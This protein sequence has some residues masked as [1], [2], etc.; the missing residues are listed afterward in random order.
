MKS[1]LLCVL[2]LLDCGS[3]SLVW[4][5]T[6][7]ADFSVQQVLQETQKA[8]DQGQFEKAL[9]LLDSI[10]QQKSE[11]PPAAR[12]RMLSLVQVGKTL[13]GLDEYEKH[14]KTVG[15]EDE[16]L[17]RQLAI[18]SILPLRSDMREQMRGAAYT[19]LKEINSNEVVPFLEQGLADGSGMVRALAAEGL[20]NVSAGRASD[21]FR[22]ALKDQAGWVRANVATGLGRS[23]DKNVIPLIKPLLKDDQAVVQVT[24]AAAMFNLGQ[25]E[26]W[27]RIEKAAASEEGYERGTAMRLLGNLGDPRA[28][29]ILVNGMSDRQPSIRVAAASALGKLGLSQ[30]IP[31]LAEALSKGIPALRTAAA[32]SLGRLEAT[33]LIPRLKSSLQDADPGVQT[34]S[35]DAL[36]RLRIPYNVVDPT[37]RK[38]IGDKNPGIRSGAA[39][40]L[41]NGE[42]RDVVGPLT[43]LLKDPVPRPRIASV[44]SLGRVGGR[45]TFVQLKL[46]LR[47]QDAAVRATAAGALARILATPAKP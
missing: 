35:V 4:G 40:A 2:V 47:D 39:K 5:E 26:Q 29:P 44:R 17:L 22:Q 15:G 30:A 36:L 8:Y 13:E 37:I 46:A 9:Q 41:A 7:R 3:T 25:I 33:Q 43:L 34:A 20:G 1:F 21:K 32:V 6:E 38:L 12:L 18:A 14:I 28:L 31:Y 10:K 19:A 45:T 27:S 24:A 16:T 42:V 11:P 23:R